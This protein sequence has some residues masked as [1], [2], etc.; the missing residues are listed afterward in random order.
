[1]S[2]L[3]SLDTGD[4]WRYKVLVS[5]CKAVQLLCCWFIFFF[6][7]IFVSIKPSSPCRGLDKVEGVWRA[8]VS[9]KSVMCMLFF[10]YAHILVGIKMC[11]RCRDA[12]GV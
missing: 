8:F 6:L 9:V 11:V 4:R 3:P 2:S 12:K 7:N 10:L 5:V 1:M